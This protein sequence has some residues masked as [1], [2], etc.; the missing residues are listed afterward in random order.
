M[1]QKTEITQLLDLMVQPGF[2][3]NDNI[4]VNVNQAARGLLISPGDDVRTMLDTGLEEFDAFDSGCLYLQLKLGSGCCGAAVMGVDGLKVFVL[5]QGTEK[6]ELY[7]LALAAQNLR[8]PVSKI[9]IAADQLSQTA[10][11]L[12]DTAAIAQAG[13][14]NRGLHQLFRI[15]NNMSDTLMYTELSRQETRNLTA[16]F[17]EIFEK[18]ASLLEQTGLH[19]TYEGLDE[20]VFALADTQQLERA[21]LNVLSNASRF[22]PPGSTVTARLTRRG[23]LLR[24]SIEDDGPGI[25]DDVLNHIFH[26]YLRRPGIEDGRFGIGLGMVLVRTVAGNH[27]GTVLIDRPKGTRVTMTIAL[28]QCHD[29]LFRSPLQVDYTGGW[30]PMLIELSQSLPASLY[31]PDKN[32]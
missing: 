18:A 8:S 21:V 29:D 22:A 26:R 12:N 32:Q 30:D 2:C 20:D 19:I 17:S 3:V 31:E 16:V 1:D 10:A 24:L 15:I 5:D 9:M 7:A 11:T 25:Q 28:R 27:G 4:I 6:G 14:L 23:E 13:Q